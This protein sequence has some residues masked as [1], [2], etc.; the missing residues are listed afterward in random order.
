LGIE[1]DDED[2]VLSHPTMAEGF[3]A[4]FAAL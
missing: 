2:T 1:D 3:N 4:L